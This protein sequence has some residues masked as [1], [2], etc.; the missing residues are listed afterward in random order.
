MEGLGTRMGGGA[1]KLEAVHLRGLPLP[2]LSNDASAE[3]SRLGNSLEQDDIE[4]QKRIDH[5]VVSSLMNRSSDLLVIE[6]AVQ[7]LREKMDS[8]C[9]ARQK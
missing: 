2:V 8:L 1:L 4:R 5:V 3:L 9:R 6:K 7:K